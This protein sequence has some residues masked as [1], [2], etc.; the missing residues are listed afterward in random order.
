MS[1]EYADKE[2]IVVRISTNSGESGDERRCFSLRAQT[3][4]MRFEFYK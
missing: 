2:R 4:V 3:R 1:C